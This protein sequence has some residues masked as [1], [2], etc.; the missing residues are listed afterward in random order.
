MK[1]FIDI[2]SEQMEA[3]AKLR[4]EI[5]KVLT[6]DSHIELDQ[7][8]K[9]RETDQQLI[10]E[11]FTIFNGFPN[12][13]SLTKEEIAQKLGDDYKDCYVYYFKGWYFTTY[14]MSPFIFTA[15]KK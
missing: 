1:R 15:F 13:H 5:K 14:S 2:L 10:S 9:G 12:V 11:I 7:Y 4:A 6:Q 8:M 3:K